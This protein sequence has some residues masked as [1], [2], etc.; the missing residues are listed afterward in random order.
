[1]V[2]T[3]VKVPRVLDAD[4][5]EHVLR[6][7]EQIRGC[8]QVVLDAS[9]YV[10]CSPIGMTLLK[11]AMH[12]QHDCRVID[13]IWMDIQRASYLSRMDFFSG[14]DAP[15]LVVQNGV[16]HD[17]TDRLIEL[18]VVPND[19]HVDEYADRIAQT[20]TKS[21]LR[22]ATVFQQDDFD[23]EK[24]IAPIRYLVSELLLNA[25]THSRRHGHHGAKAWMS[26]Q[27]RAATPKTAAWIEIAIVDDGCGVL[28]TLADQLNDRGSAAEAIETAM[29]PMVS[30]NLGIDMTGEE[31]SNQGVGLYVAK[32]LILSAGGRLQIISDNC[33]YDSKIPTR[34]GQYRDLRNN[35]RGVAISITMP[36]DKIYGLNPTSSLDRISSTSDSGIA[37]N[38]S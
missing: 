27:A 30:C 28:R 21:L 5:V 34:S 8:E 26:A 16:R 23:E 2:T 18:Q 4:N 31:T 32:D 10:Y 29:K 14:V 38:F 33:L 24:I 17:R 13:V 37:L 12:S 7:C 1:M 9:E 36:F 3:V 15:S 6:V 25:T 19:L 22:E 11:S 20:L 35:W